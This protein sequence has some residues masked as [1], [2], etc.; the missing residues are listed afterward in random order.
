MASWSCDS[1]HDL[2]MGVE[3]WLWGIVAA[4]LASPLVGLGLFLLM[5]RYM[6]AATSR[7]PFVL[8][9][10]PGAPAAPLEEHD[11]DG[12]MR[13]LV[14][15]MCLLPG[16]LSFSG[17]W[18]I[19]GNDK[20]DERIDMLLA[21]LDHYDVMLLNEMW[22]CWWSSFHTRFFQLATERGFY[23]CASPVLLPPSLS[24]V[25]LF[26]FVSTDSQCLTSCLFCCRWVC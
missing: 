13:L 5:R 22:G 7:I 20:K 3:G 19:D 10:A 6:A 2:C 26:R 24:A 21:N 17:S 1:Q 16:G 9:P 14:L 8:Q 25:L 11:R 18:L 15:N 4:W 23:V 12:T